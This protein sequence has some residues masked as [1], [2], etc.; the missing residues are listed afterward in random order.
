QLCDW[1]DRHVGRVREP[2]TTEFQIGT[3]AFGDA[4]GLGLFEIEHYR[5][6]LRYKD[7]LAGRTPPVI[8]QDFPI[9]RL[10][11]SS[12][13]ER[14]SWLASHEK[15]HETLRPFANV[16][17]PN[18]ADVNMDDPEAF[19]DWLSIHLTEHQLLDAAFGL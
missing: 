8:I 10:V 15:L 2:M 6:H 5:Q 13:S 11:G 16:S 17:G 12:K 4:A 3:L 18:Y 9:M 19:N 1:A 14:A 7:A